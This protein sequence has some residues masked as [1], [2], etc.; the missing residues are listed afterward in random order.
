MDPTLSIIP[1][2]IEP[3]SSKIKNGSQNTEYQ[4]LSKEN[5]NNLD[6]ERKE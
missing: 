5:L 3:T 4:K 1:E 2:I 6:E